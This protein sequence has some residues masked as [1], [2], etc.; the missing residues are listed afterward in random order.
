MQFSKGTVMP[1][2]RLK[3]NREFYKMESHQRTY[4]GAQ[5][6]FYWKKHFVKPEVRQNDFEIHLNEAQFYTLDFLP[7]QF[8]RILQ[9]DN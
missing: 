8:Q 2:I 5:K 6:S 9:K 7:P 4:R 1:N 3:V